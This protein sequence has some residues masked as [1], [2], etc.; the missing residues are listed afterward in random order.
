MGV[1]GGGGRKAGRAVILERNETG[2]RVNLHLDHL[3]LI[4]QSGV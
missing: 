4:P 2:K 3:V 1:G